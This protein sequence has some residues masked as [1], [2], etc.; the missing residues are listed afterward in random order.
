M[1]LRLAIMDDLSQLKNMYKEIIKNMNSNNINIWDEIYPCEFFQL[2]IE[3][4]QLYILLDNDEIISAFT[5]SYSNIGDD[6]VNWKDNTARALYIEKLGVNV[7]YLRKGIGSIVLNKV[8]ELSKEMN[9]EYLRLFVV[10]E[11]Y[12]AIN[13][14]KKAGFEKVDGIYDEVIDNNLVL[15]EFGFEKKIDLL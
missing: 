3:N 2:D 11:N 7:K 9:V 5:L 8:M 10:D 14:Y 15:H 4:N 1:E 6:S 13:L 12:P